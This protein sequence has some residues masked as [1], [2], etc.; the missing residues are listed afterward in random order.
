VSHADQID[1]NPNNNSASATET[2]QQADLALSKTV[3]NSTPIVGD[4]ITYTVT[5]TDHGPDAVTNVMVTDLLPGGLNFVSSSPSQGTYNSTTGNWM[6]GTVTTSTPQTLIIAATVVSPGTQTNTATVSHVDQFDPNIANNSASAT[7]TP[8]SDL[9]LSQPANLTVD[10]TSPA[11]AT[12]TYALPS[13]TDEDAT[14]P[15]PS[16]TP[17]SG[18]TFAIG[19]T[20]VTCTVTDSDDTNSPVSRSFTVA[21]KGAAA[22]LSDLVTLV[23]SM[24]LGNGLQ[25]SFDT[26]LG[27]VQTDLQ[28]ANNTKQSCNDLGAFISHIQ[29]QSGKLLTTA[30]ANQLLGP[31]NNLSKTLGC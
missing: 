17:A 21:V 12:V 29:A 19:T 9:A 16:C 2:P 24:G 23:N 8:D 20:A 18:T 15:T 6:V 25:G 11:G 5:L 4:T 26:Q 13:V 31:A 7:E 1:P 27:A 3:S 22:Q 30:R 14:K 10:A 28:Q